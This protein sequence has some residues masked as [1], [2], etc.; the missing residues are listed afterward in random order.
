[1]ATKNTPAAGNTQP[2]DA[3]AR[4]QQA[5]EQLRVATERHEAVTA[6]LS[7]LGGSAQDKRQAQA[8]KQKV[9][10]ALRE[11]RRLLQEAQAH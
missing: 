2:A 1:M 3:Q 10:H 5:Q 8:E 9:D 4:L 11:A 7:R 6:A